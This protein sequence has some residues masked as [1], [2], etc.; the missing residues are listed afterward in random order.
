M[1]RAD[2]FIFCRAIHGW[3]TLVHEV[4]TL[5]ALWDNKFM[6]KLIYSLTTSI[7]GCISDKDGNFEWTKPSEEVLACVNGNLHN[8]GTFLL[9]RSMYETLAVW[10]TL[11]T[12]G[13]SKGMNDF[14]KIWRAAKKIV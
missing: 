9:G 8:V 11:P 2:Y 13:P 4:Q 1:V 7:D 14:A 6:G 3:Y 12:D 10:D 5:L